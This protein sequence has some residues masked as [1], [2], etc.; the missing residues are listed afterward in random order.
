M[1]SLINLCNFYKDSCLLIGWFAFIISTIYSIRWQ[2]IL[3]HSVWVSKSEKLFTIALSVHIYIR[4]LKFQYNLQTFA[5]RTRLIRKSMCETLR[6]AV[7]QM[8]QAHCVRL[9]WRKRPRNTS[10][11]ELDPQFVKCLLG[12]KSF[13]ML[14]W[15]FVS[16]FESLYKLYKTKNE[17][18]LISHNGTNIFIQ[19]K[20]KCIIQLGF[21]L[22]NGT[23]Y[24]SPH[25]N[26]CTIALINIHYVICILFNEHFAYRC[27]VVESLSMK[28]F[29]PHKWYK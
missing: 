27:I 8:Q 7:G 29:F 22:L 10:C 23:F 24:L 17:C 13:S 15:K 21:A 6:G 26:I 19:W 2:N 11:I 25:E 9:G 18:F 3:L 20:V 4:V 12:L 5:L 28:G 16:E 1:P 14:F